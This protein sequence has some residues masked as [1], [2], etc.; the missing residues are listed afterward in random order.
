MATGKPLHRSGNTGKGT[1]RCFPTPHSIPAWTTGNPADR[2]SFRAP[3]SRPRRKSDVCLEVSS[4]RWWPRFDL[5][6]TFW[7]FCF[8]LHDFSFCRY[9]HR[10]CCS[11]RTSTKSIVTFFYFCILRFCLAFF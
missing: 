10:C 8:F 6:H 1:S 7:S 5:C 2:S 11:T 3:C 9:Y 4:P